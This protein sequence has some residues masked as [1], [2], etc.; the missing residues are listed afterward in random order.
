MYFI[1]IGCDLINLSL[2][3][4]IE[5]RY[6]K[7]I[8]FFIHGIPVDYKLDDITYMNIV[9]DLMNAISIDLSDELGEL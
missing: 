7:I 1:R 5:L 2:V 3:S 6:G 9:E 8:R 4:R